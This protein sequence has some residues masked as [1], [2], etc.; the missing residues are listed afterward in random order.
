MSNQNGCCIQWAKI[1]DT[2]GQFTNG[3]TEGK[4]ALIFESRIWFRNPFLFRFRP[5]IRSEDSVETSGG[6]GRQSDAPES[7]AAPAH[8]ARRTTCRTTWR[9]DPQITSRGQQ[10]QTN[11]QGMYNWTKSWFYFFGNNCSQVGVKQPWFHHWWIKLW[12]Y[13]LFKKK[14]SD[15]TMD[16]LFEINNDFRFSWAAVKSM[17]EI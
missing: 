9:S 1:A 12:F 7:D 10:Q 16:L 4:R 3:T 14:E 2:Q 11:Q 13:F 5:V 15:I 17:C 8:A 6:E